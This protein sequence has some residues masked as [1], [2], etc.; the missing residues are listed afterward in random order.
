MQAYL[1]IALIFALIVAIISIQNATGV[2]IRL[3]YWSFTN[4]S[5]V[6]VIL[7]S[8]AA[9]AICAFL[10]GMPKQL[11]VNRKIREL[12]ANSQRLQAEID[13][14]KSHSPAPIQLSENNQTSQASSRIL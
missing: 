6:L 7:G 13:Q 5:L 2:D 4:I 9:G 12:Q 14:L 8:A 11:S 10:L 3:F 1:I